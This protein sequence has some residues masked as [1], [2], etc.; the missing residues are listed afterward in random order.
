MHNPTTLQVGLFGLRIFVG[1]QAK[2]RQIAVFLH[3]NLYIKYYHPLQYL[4][5]QVFYLTNQSSHNP[6]AQYSSILQL[7]KRPPAYPD[8]NNI[9][10]FSSQSFEMPSSVEYTTSRP[11]SYDFEDPVQAMTDYSRLM[12]K[13]T[14]SQMAAATQ[15]VRRRGSGSPDSQSNSATLRKEGSIS[16]QASY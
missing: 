15:A 9:S 12:H 13:H 7:A 3:L 5:Q 2:R 11:E 16:S 6:S 1:F 4:L 10:N 14:K 8:N